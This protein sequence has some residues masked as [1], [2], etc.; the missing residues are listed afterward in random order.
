MFCIFCLCI[1]WIKNKPKQ[2]LQ[3][4]L[5]Q[6]TGNFTKETTE[7]EAKRIYDERSRTYDQVIFEMKVK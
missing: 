4:T 7:D 1:E 2:A 3:S 6:K 5:E